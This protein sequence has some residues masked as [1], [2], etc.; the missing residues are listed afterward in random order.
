M[1]V[2]IH[3]KLQLQMYFLNYLCR[4]FTEH[5][6]GRGVGTIF[7]AQHHQ[8]SGYFTVAAQSWSA[9]EIRRWWEGKVWSDGLVGVA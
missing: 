7:H 9:A 8:Y 2:L 5:V 1:S 6:L 3:R 4:Y